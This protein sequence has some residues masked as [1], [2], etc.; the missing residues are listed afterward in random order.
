VSIQ[1]GGPHGE[2]RADTRA[3]GG[4]T[5]KDIEPVWVDDVTGDKGP[6]ARFRKDASIGACTVISPDKDALIGGSAPESVGTG[7]G[8]SVKGAHLLNST[9]WMTRSICDVY[10]CRKDFYDAN[11]DF[12]RKFTAGYLKACEEILVDKE[13]FAKKQPVPRYTA[14]LKMAK[15]IFGDA[16]IPSLDDAHGLICDCNMVLLPGNR[17]FFTDKR[18]M[19]GFDRKQKKVLDIAEALGNVT[20][21]AEFLKPEAEFDYDG[22]AALVGLQVL[23]ATESAGPQSG[24]ERVLHTFSISFDPNEREFKTE[25]Y[26]Q[27]F[28]L[29]LEQ[30]AV[31]GGAAIVIRGHVDP[32]EVLRAFLSQ[33]QANGSVRRTLEAGKE[34][35][36]FNDQ[37]IDLTKTA[38]VMKAIK[39]GKFEQA[40][41][42]ANQATALSQGRADAVLEALRGFAKSKQVDL[43]E[44]QFTSVGVGVS[45]PIFPLSKTWEEAKQNMR[46]E[47]RLQTF[48]PESKSSAF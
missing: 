9:A 1:K 48:P 17:R 3:S 29:A 43:Q 34:V 39:G 36:Y 32:T 15:E 5:W 11:K 23:T 47:F 26:L 14:D 46:V 30:A 6:A 33:G 42:L 41:E 18:F 4:L 24:F 21:R 16:F 37:P 8:D 13:V 20:S 12:I 35:Y 28:Q 27:E 10:A 31:C 44:N 45:E 22:L 38:V 40:A 19:V 2:R 25:R 7:K